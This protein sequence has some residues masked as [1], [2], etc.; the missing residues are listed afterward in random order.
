MRIAFD[1]NGLT[2]FL[3]ANQEGYDPDSDPDAEL[4]T[5]RK[6][7][8]LLWLYTDNPVIV[9]TVARE[10][11][12]IRDDEKWHEHQRWTEL[13]LHEVIEKWL[14]ADQI[15]ARVTE[16][17]AFHKKPSDCRIVAECEGV[18]SVTVDALA[19][20]DGELLKKLKD[21]S[22]VRIA[23]PDECW[24]CATVAPGTTPQVKLAPEHPLFGVP[25]LRV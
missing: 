7:S 25:W 23:T 12:R 5:Q 10:N 8:L 21:G 1:S 20:F 17:E 14:D 11:Q 2:Y 15:A 6:A 4:A 3:Q 24:Q 18:K 13:H 16:L 22:K 9:P 19:T